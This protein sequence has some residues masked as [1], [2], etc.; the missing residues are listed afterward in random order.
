VRKERGQADSDRVRIC[1]RSINTLQEIVTTQCRVWLL[2]AAAVAA[3][4]AHVLGCVLW[5]FLT[6]ARKPL[7]HWIPPLVIPFNISFF[8]LLT[9]Y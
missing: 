9:F 5:Y 3:A 4:A 1:F 6:L 8:F 7:H 2:F